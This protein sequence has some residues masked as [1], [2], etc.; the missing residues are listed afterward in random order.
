M[1]GHDEEIESLV[2]IVDLVTTIVVIHESLSK[3]TKTKAIKRNLTTHKH[4]L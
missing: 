2:P 4:Q 3:L 1:V